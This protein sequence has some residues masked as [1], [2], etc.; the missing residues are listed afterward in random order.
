MTSRRSLYIG[1]D[2]TSTFTTQNRRDWS[3]QEFANQVDLGAPG[4]HMTIATTSDSGEINLVPAGW[5]PVTPVMTGYTLDEQQRQGR[6]NEANARLAAAGG[7]P[8]S[9]GPKPVMTG[10]TLNAAQRAGRINEAAAR[11]AAANAMSVAPVVGGG[12]TNGYGPSLNLPVNTPPRLGNGWPGLNPVPPPKLL[13]KTPG[14]LPPPKVIKTGYKLTPAQQKGRINEAA[15]RLAAAKAKAAA[16][17]RAKAAAAK[18]P[19]KPPTPYE[20]FIESKLKP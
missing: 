4:Q 11:L 3:G 5:S 15:A 17:A 20:R 12:P 9:L 13:P 16:T 7:K 10:Y 6:I 18:A 14:P 8:S 1:R 2:R 19:P